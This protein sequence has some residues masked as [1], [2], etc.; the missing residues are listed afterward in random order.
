MLDRGVLED[1]TFDE[2]DGTF[3][4]RCGCVPRPL[5]PPSDRTAPRTFGRR[6]KVAHP[7]R[8]SE[9]VHAVTPHPRVLSDDADRAGATIRTARPPHRRTLLQATGLA[10]AAALALAACGPT[11][12]QPETDP[13]P[14][15]SPQD[16]AEEP[17][18][19]A[20]PD[21][22]IDGEEATGT[23]EPQD[24]QEDEEAAAVAPLDVE[25][26]TSTSE[27]D[28]V[29]GRL[30]VTDVRV[31]THDG[32]D[33]A[34][35]ELDGEGEVGWF[36]ELTEEPTSQGSGEPIEFEGEVAL[37]LA[38][39]MVTLPGDEPAGVDEEA[40]VDMDLTVAGPA[41]GV[42]T[43]VVG[44]TLFEGLQTFA[45]GLDAERPYRIERFEDPERIVIDVLHD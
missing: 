10:A 5:L 17:D 32:F 30:I 19:E 3:E 44:D 16:Q 31:G 36:T 26:T 40:R 7:A 23:D 8:L 4:V 6:P 33:R 13:E 45:I 42:I 27:R 28:S 29:D 18:D 35:V 2:G 21:D 22:A 24:S 15:E 20:D 9:A 34:T 39:Q 25:E 37:W 11:D 1:D 43:E 14:I 41:G 12:E 38:A